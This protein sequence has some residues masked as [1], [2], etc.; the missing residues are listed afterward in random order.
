MVKME[1]KDDDK[2]ASCPAQYVSNLFPNLL[3]NK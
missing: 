3:W 1:R 2:S